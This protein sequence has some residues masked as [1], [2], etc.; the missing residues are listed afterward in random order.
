MPKGSTRRSRSTGSLPWQACSLCFRISLSALAMYFRS[1]RLAGLSAGVGNVGFRGPVSLVMVSRPV[2]FAALKTPDTSLLQISQLL[3]GHQPPDYP[4]DHL[5]GLGVQVPITL[6]EHLVFL[7]VGL[8][9]LA[10]EVG[11]SVGAQ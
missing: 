7:I 8:V 2:G 6:K 1:T 5:L 9:A 10:E 3:V 11:L 4:A